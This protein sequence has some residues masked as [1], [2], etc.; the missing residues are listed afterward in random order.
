MEERGILRPQSLEDRAT[1]P[2]ITYPILR[3]AASLR[4]NE[5]GYVSSYPRVAFLVGVLIHGKLVASVGW[6]WT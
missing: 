1:G 4:R 2:A 6:M 5:D 3:L